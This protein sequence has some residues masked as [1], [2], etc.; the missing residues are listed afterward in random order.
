MTPSCGAAGTAGPG[1]ACAGAGT[2]AP[3]S[4]CLGG[5]TA[6]A[7][8]AFC[9]TD[10]DCASEGGICV[11]TLSNGSGGSIPNEMLCSGS[12]DP[13]ANTGCV[14]GMGCQ[15]G[16]EPTGQM[17][18]FSVCESAGKG[19]KNGA[20]TTVADCAAKFDCVNTGSQTVCL[21]YCYVGVTQAGC[22]TCTPLSAGTAMTPLVLN[23]KQVG[24]CQ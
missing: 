16:V 20:C 18:V 22:T 7:C 3:G 11:L 24:V 17:R 14:T 8:A 21:E 5:G 10:A 9:A 1:Q 13:V 12:C 2:C 15:V 23:G 19:V 4:I 6:G